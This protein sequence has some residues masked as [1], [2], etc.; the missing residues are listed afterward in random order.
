MLCPPP[1]KEKSCIRHWVQNPAPQR[2]K[3]RRGPQNL[4]MVKTR[5]EWIPGIWVQSDGNYVWVTPIAICATL[6]KNKAAC[7]EHTSFSTGYG[8]RALR[9]SFFLTRLCC[10]AS[11][12]WANFFTIT[13]FRVL[14]GSNHKTMHSAH[15][16]SKSKATRKECRCRRRHRMKWRHCEN[17]VNE[18][19]KPLKLC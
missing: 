16:K 10:N 5:K 9:P 18:L 1:S 3:S 13:L 11:W 8:F 6:S 12:S 19:L 14:L 15:A 17:R 2:E 7:I 4:R